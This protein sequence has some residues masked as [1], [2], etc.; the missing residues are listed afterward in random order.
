MDR[1]RKRKSAADRRAEIIDTVIALSADIGPDRVTTQHLAD[2]VGVTQ[3]AIFRHFSTKTEIWDAVSARITENVIEAAKPKAESTGAHLENDT[4]PEHLGRYFRLVNQR[5]SV[6]S[7]LHSRELQARNEALRLRFQTLMHNRRTWIADL[8]HRG[9]RD[10][11]HRA[12]LG[13]KDMANLILNA[14]QGLS[15]QWTLEARGFDLITEGE[16]LT[17]TLMDSIRQP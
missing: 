2:R 17:D 9:Q 13:A 11:Q 7:I 8:V 3:P 14:V 4:I 10:G 15:M 1:T 6:P 5:P 16:R 12:D